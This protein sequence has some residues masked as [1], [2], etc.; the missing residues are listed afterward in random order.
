MYVFFFLN[1]Y[2]LALRQ[3]LTFPC[4]I[5]DHIYIYFKV[6]DERTMHSIVVIE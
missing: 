4:E 2:I 6:T 3:Y 5:M 1:N